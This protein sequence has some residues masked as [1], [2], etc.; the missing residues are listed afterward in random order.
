M[1]TK[2]TITILAILT[3]IIVSCSKNNDSVPFALSKTE[4]KGC[5]IENP[6]DST[7]NELYGM[8]DSLYC[9]VE[10]DSLLLHVIMHYNC[11]GA[12]NDSVVIND[13]N[14]SIYIRDTCSSSCQCFCIC[15]YEFEYS[16]VNFSGD[17]VNFYVYLKGYEENEYALWRDLIYPL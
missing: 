1:K 3:I 16:F 11:C 14:V 10:N 2:I 7:K 13:R 9:T 6:T 8:R 4:Y 15:E 17:N 5:F 12:L